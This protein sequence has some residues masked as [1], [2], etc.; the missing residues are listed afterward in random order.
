MDSR[1]WGLVALAAALGF[2]WWAAK[3]GTV[4]ALAGGGAVTGG[5]S[6]TVQTAPTDGQ[7]VAQAPQPIA[8]A[9]A[10]VV[11]AIVVQ[12]VTSAPPPISTQP[13]PL[14]PTPAQVLP[15]P[16]VVASVGDMKVPIDAAIDP[17]A[18]DPF[19]AGVSA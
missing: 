15:D 19:A 8:V 18:S 2:Y 13:N 17:V 10:P 5:T 6:G 14:P 16:D 1:R 11:A 9:G 3:R 12:P 7:T 4:P